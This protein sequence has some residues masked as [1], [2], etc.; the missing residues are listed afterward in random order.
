MRLCHTP[1]RWFVQSWPER[2][3]PSFQDRRAG[4]WKCHF[5]STPQQYNQYIDGRLKQ[6]KNASR[7]RYILP[8]FRLLG[9]LHVLWRKLIASIDLFSYTCVCKGRAVVVVVVGVMERMA[10]LQS[11]YGDTFT[12][13]SPSF[14][15]I[16]TLRRV[17]LMNVFTRIRIIAMVRCWYLSCYSIGISLSLSL[18]SS[19]LFWFCFFPRGVL[20]IPLFP[21]HSFLQFLRMIASE[22]K[23]VENKKKK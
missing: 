20:F 21:S 14:L 18:S 3:C 7:L 15:F 2:S 6:K 22:R 1:Y 10:C 13:L 16:L 12:F 9:Q 8:L 4:T 23:R 11:V 5:E 19:S 17:V